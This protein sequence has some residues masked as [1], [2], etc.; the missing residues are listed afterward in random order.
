MRAAAAVFVGGILA[1]QQLPE[2]PPVAWA[3]LVV[4][5]LGLGWRNPR[6]LIAAFFVAGGAWVTYR[7]GAI[8]DDRLDPALEGRDIAVEGYVAD[9]PQHAEYGVR[10]PFDVERAHA[11][12]T[13]VRLPPRILLALLEPEVALRAGEHWR[14]TVRLKRPHGAQNPGGFDY[15]AFLFRSHIGAK[16]YVRNAPAPER[17]NSDNSTRYAVDRLRQKLGDRIATALAGDPHAGI[18]IALANGDARGIDEAQWEVLRRTGTLHLVAISGLHISLVAGLV[19]FIVRFIWSWP[20]VTVLLVPA[21]VVGAIAGLAAATLYAAAAGFVIPTQ[22]ALIML[23]VAM[24]AVIARRRFPPS[25]L[26]A[27]AALLV[28]LYDPLAVMATGFWLSFAAVV[29]IVYAMQTDVERAWWRRWG[30]VQW[31]IA[32]GMLPIMLVLFRQ[33]SLSAPLANMLAVPVFDL[34]LVPLILGAL[35]SLPVSDTL[36][37]LLLQAA[38]GLLDRLWPALDF[39]SA[40]EYG[41]WTQAPPPAWAIACALVGVALI[42]VPRGFPA[43]IVGVVWLLPALLTRAPGP[44]PGEAWFT[45]LDVGQ[46]LAAVVRTHGHTLVYDAG[47]RLSPRFDN[48]AAVVV[49]FLH[50]RD[51]TRID[52]F[53]VSHGDNDHAGGAAAVM[54]RLP[55]AR[56]LSSVPEKISTRAEPCHAGQ[57]WVWDD[58]EFEI[59]SPLEDRPD[60]DN[61]ASCV[62]RVH[63]RH[64]TVLLP[65]DIEKDAEGRLIERALEGL[66]ADVLVAPHHGSRTSST[67]AFIDA[68]KPRHVLFPIGYRNRYRH[69]HPLVVQRYAAAGAQLHDSASAGAIDVRFAAAGMQIVHY[70]DTHRH[71]WSTAIA[72][73]APAP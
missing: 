58:V 47:A 43:R 62:L 2:L 45:L 48:G 36:A 57:R 27:I 6:W 29:V 22:R 25:R 54:Q 55:V 71:Y 8:L 9:L 23:A 42:L 15:E 38:A 61:D 67:T 50:T 20:G 24:G 35:V 3:L 32:I 7:A 73:V 53:I 10:F 33:V 37:T 4:P 26:L 46:G 66:A 30:Y 17:L 40:L 5:M 52:T 34:L 11:E 65:G 49:P 41:Q 63:S 60:P 19:F 68:V 64:G 28:T 44:A 39:L 59:L 69:P 13:A 14:F 21:P 1:V 56:V 31:A 18:V 70:R 51:V 12:N 72:P 16:G